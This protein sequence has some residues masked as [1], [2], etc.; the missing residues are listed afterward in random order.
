MTVC[1]FKKIYGIVMD[2]YS[3]KETGY[4]IKKAVR[5]NILR[6]FVCYTIWKAKNENFLQGTQL[7]LT[8]AII[9]IG[10]FSVMNLLN[11]VVICITVRYNEFSLMRS[12]GMSPK[13]L[14]AMVHKEGLIV[15]GI[16]LGLSVIIG[17]GIGFALCSFLK[18]NLMS[19]LNYKFPL[20]IS[21]LYCAIILLCT[22]VISTGALKQQS[23]R[24]FSKWPA[25]ESGKLE[26]ARRFS[27]RG[28][29]VGRFPVLFYSIWRI[30][31]T[32][33]GLIRY[34]LQPKK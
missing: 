18:S 23:K 13:Q 34:F 2:E 19:Y 28:C 11:T 5:C 3:R 1:A 17:G 14:S 15:V 24:A 29:R 25:D 22:I 21:I 8:V 26:T 33:N 10:C 7:A 6:T 32:A 12:V 4:M 27:Y 9:L 31:L 30:Y 20:E 16:G